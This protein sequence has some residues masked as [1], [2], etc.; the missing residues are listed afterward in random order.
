MNVCYLVELSDTEHDELEA[1]NRGGT[2]AVRRLKRSNIL[3]MSDR[4]HTA[5]EIEAA[6]HGS[7]LTVYRTRQRLVEH[8]VE[9]ALS[10]ERRPGGKRMLDEKQEAIL[11]AAACSSPPKGCAHWTLQ[12]LAGRFVELADLDSISA[13]TIGR[14]LREKDIKPW[15]KKMWCIP[16][17]DAAEPPRAGPPIWRMSWKSTRSHLTRCVR[18]SASTRP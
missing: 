11:V 16:E 7:T 8:G 9:A 18:L 6:G 5:E 12:F 3:L 2:E 1:L 10:E 15:Q 13:S 17:V 14:R 4:G